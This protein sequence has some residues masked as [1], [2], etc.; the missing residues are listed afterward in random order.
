MANPEFGATE[1]E[2]AR[3]VD[4]NYADGIEQPNDANLPSARV[5]SNAI[6]AQDGSTV[7]DR[8]L[9][10][11]VW[12]WGQFLDHDITLTPTTSEHGD[13]ESYDIEVPTGD[14]S[15]DPFGTGTATIPLTRSH[16]DDSSG[17]RE[18]YNA[19]SSWVDGSNVYG[20]DEATANGLREFSGG[21]L[22]T[23]EGNLLPLDDSGFFYA[24]DIRANENVALTS[25]HTVFMREHNRLA[26][27]ISSRDP[28]LTDEQIYQRARRMVISEL[29][30][31]TYNEFLPALL[32][33]NA[34][35]DYSGYKP[36]VD[37]TITNEFSTAAYRLGHSLVSSQILRVG[38]DGEV[39]DEGNLSTHDAFFNPSEVS[40]HG[41]DS[42]LRGSAIGLS[43]EVDAQIVDCLR[44]LLFGPPGAGGL[45][46]AALNIQRGRDH[47][48]GSYND[49]REALGLDRA[50][51]FADI[52]SDPDVQAALEEAYGD[53][54]L[55]D[56]W[57]GLLAEDHVANSSVG[58][59]MQ[60]ILT[61][62]FTR[63]RDGDRFWY[64][65]VFR[66]DR[67]M[68]ERIN[69]TSLKDV[70]E[71]NT[72][73][74]GL[75]D[76]VFFDAGVIIHELPTLDQARRANRIRVVV[77]DNNVVVRD[78]RSGRALHRYSRDDIKQVMILGSD[79][80]IDRVTVDVRRASEPLEGGIIFDAG[81]NGRDRLSILGTE[82]DDV[83]DITTDTVLFNGHAIYHTGVD[84]IDLRTLQRGD[85]INIAPDVTQQIMTRQ[86]DR[87]MRD[88]G[89]HSRRADAPNPTESPMTTV[90][91]RTPTGDI[92]SM[93]QL[94]ERVARNMAARGATMDDVR[95]IDLLDALS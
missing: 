9:T 8:Y 33:F 92:R 89:D 88:R 70:I 27:E 38:A 85:V 18:Q 55:V 83:V 36:N 6:V 81:E 29:Q 15:F 52:S 28:S 51:S 14:P 3:Y 41:I 21:R 42:I 53:V 47:G 60:L 75:Q 91:G 30:A 35:D 39:I 87:P 79:Q 23:S 63:L 25:L 77:T 5:V 32:G 66:G 65:N 95:N 50:E 44:N 31:I 10:D 74:E 16:Y 69:S 1:T 34:I 11:F 76:N 80:Q 71:A 49:T 57:I 61:D 12:Q 56:L 94:M 59:T 4:A 82:G 43:Q 26:D 78:I 90:A 67:R 40:E 7:N 62:Q 64:E 84:L 48:L 86:Q 93:D 17:V 72:E 58:E 24:G 20:S 54:E 45:D 13:P 73:I 68:L 19:I 22:L 2:F 37:P 46:L